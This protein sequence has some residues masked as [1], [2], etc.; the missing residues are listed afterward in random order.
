MKA[1]VGIIGG[2]GMY[3]FEGLEAAET[4]EMSTPWGEPSAPL[5]LGRIGETDVAFL[6]RHGAGHHLTPS[7]INYRANI[8]AMKRV[9]VTDLISLSACGS[10]RAELYP[11]LFVI[12]DQFIDRTYKRETSFFG[13]GCVGHVSMAHP[14]S[15][16]LSERLVAAAQ[17][18]EVPVH[19]GGSYVCIEGPQFSSLAESLNY[20]A[21][22]LDVI[23]MTA[24]IEAKLAREAELS[25]ACVSMVTDFDCWH[26]GHAA[27]DVAEV[28]QVMHQNRG[29]AHRLILQ[30]LTNFPSQH[31]VCPQGSNSALDHAIMTAKSARDPEL[32]AKLATIA[33]RVLTR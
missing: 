18:A 4:R 25:Y 22:G 1:R 24:A 11:G 14:T 17:A 21:A 13:N 20:K 23:G 8:D 5:R 27:V 32:V 12:V 10:F 9:G 31:E 28:V 3:D 30:L 29:A 19:M 7:G 16:L 26:I 15:S 2:S 6:P 33:G